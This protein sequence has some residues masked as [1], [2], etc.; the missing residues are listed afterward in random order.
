MNQ[1]W[2]FRALAGW[3]EGRVVSTDS[4]LL[5]DALSWVFTGLGFC[6]LEAAIFRDLVLARAIEPTSLLDAARVLS[7]LGRSPVSCATMK[8]TLTRCLQRGYRD[9]VAAQSSSRKILVPSGATGEEKDGPAKTDE[10]WVDAS[11]CLKVREKESG[12]GP[13]SGMCR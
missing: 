2:W 11:S 9:Q 6:A 7:D 5:F 4:R 10:P 3:L 8:R 1:L 12:T 13:R